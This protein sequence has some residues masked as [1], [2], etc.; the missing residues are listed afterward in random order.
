MTRDD[1]LEM[2]RS[3]ARAYRRE[4]QRR[5]KRNPALAAQLDRW[6][7]SALTRAE[8]IRCGPLFEVER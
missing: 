1:L 5:R 2:E 6:S 3:V 8:A 4:A 7:Q